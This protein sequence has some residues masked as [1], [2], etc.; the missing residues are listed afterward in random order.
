MD[1]MFS[2]VKT[3]NKLKHIPV[4]VLTSSEKEE[5]IIKS[6][7]LYANCY[8]TKPLRFTDFIKVVS[9]IE[10]FWFTIVSFS[11]GPLT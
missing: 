1:P 11:S 3:D 7:Q 8:I 2:T 4:V 6:Y 10:S 9:S 5:D